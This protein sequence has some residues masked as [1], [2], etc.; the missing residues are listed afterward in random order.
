[1]QKTIKSCSICKRLFVLKP[2]VLNYDFCK[3]CHIVK[4]R[5]IENKLIKYMKDKYLIKK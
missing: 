2:Y 5:K 1:M 3:Y 4:Q